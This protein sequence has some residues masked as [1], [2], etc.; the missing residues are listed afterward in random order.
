MSSTTDNCTSIPTNPMSTGNKGRLRHVALW[1]AGLGILLLLLVVNVISVIQRRNVHRVIQN[2]LL[3]LH[4]LIPFLRNYE[5][6]PI[7]VQNV[8]SKI[9]R[10]AQRDCRTNLT[11]YDEIE[12]VQGAKLKSQNGGLAKE[13]ETTNNREDEQTNT[14]MV[15]E[16]DSVY[17]LQRTVLSTNL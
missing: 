15:Q 6:I 9:L 4:T 5:D 7:N 12:M 16:R 17:S 3:S 14:G 1:A 13:T 11:E 8:E 2:Y 10:K